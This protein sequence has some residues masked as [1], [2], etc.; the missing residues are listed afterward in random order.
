[1]TIKFWKLFSQ[2][3]TWNDPS[4]GFPTMTAHGQSPGLDS[5]PLTI[6]VLSLMPQIEVDGDAVT[7]GGGVAGGWAE[8]VL[9][10]FIFIFSNIMLQN[11]HW[12]FFLFY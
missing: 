10:M 11:T 7:D 8:G 6:L 12:K 3:L 1:M 2:N 5:C 4:F 9:K